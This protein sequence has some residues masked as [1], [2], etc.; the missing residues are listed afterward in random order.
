M[1]QYSNLQAAQTQVVTLLCVTRKGPLLKGYEKFKQTFQ[2]KTQ[3]QKSLLNFR[4]NK[5][6]LSVCK[7]LREGVRA[8]FWG[9]V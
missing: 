7:I 5:L 2:L 9:G 8:I 3:F 4:L 6:H 1:D